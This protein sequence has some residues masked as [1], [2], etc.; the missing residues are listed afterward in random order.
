MNLYGQPTEEIWFHIHPKKRMFI[1]GL[2][3]V[4]SFAQYANQTSR[5]IYSTYELQSTFPGNV[6]TSV[7]FFTSFTCAIIAG[8]RQLHEEAAIRKQQ[9]GRFPPG[10]V[11]IAKRYVRSLRGV[12]EEE[13]DESSSEDVAEDE[14]SFTE[15]EEKERRRCFKGL[16][17]WLKTDRTSL[18][19]WGL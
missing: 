7:F 4:N 2:L 8:I 10:P 6:L 17:R 19:M 5:I 18:D 9:P 1:V 15:R 13:A 11:A 14:M 3:V 12:K 16:R